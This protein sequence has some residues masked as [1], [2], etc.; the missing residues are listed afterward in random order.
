LALHQENQNILKNIP[1]ISS[2]ERIQTPPLKE[3]GVPK[4][5]CF[6][7]LFSFSYLFFFLLII[8]I[9]I[10]MSHFDSAESIA[11]NTLLIPNI[12]T[13]FFGSDDA[14]LLI[15]DACAAFGPLYTFVKMK[16]FGRLMVIY[17]DTA[18]SIKAKQQLDRNHLI[19]KEREPFPEII[20]LT[21]LDETDI[22]AWVDLGYKVLDLRVYYGQVKREKDL[23]ISCNG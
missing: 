16:G 12:P 21:K 4:Q 7:S 13:C 9:T 20:S 3:A 22:K 14:M 1:L 10:I 15:H 19:W 11:T 17:R 8:A 18:N 5:A 6:I 23:Y 2:D